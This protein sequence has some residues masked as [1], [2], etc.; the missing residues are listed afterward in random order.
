MRKEPYGV[1]S[2]VHVVKRGAKGTPIVRNDDDRWRFLKLMR[3]LNSAT[4]PRHWERYVTKEHIANNFAIPKE[5]LRPQPYVSILAYCLQDN[6][7]HLLVREELEG[8]ISKFMQRLCTSMSAYFN[9]KYSDAGTLFQSAYRAR[10]VDNDEY[11]QHLAAYIMV[12]NVFERYPTGVRGAMKEFHK[13]M[14]TSEAYPFSSL[15]VYTRNL[16]SGL[17]AMKEIDELFE[18]GDPFI[19]AAREAMLGRIEDPRFDELTLDDEPI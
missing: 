19:R 10:T 3:Y 2:I 5:W 4:V 12:K 11:L 18:R 9:A 8:G 17:L 7:F 13:A 16:N 6:H 15:P 1:G 14:S